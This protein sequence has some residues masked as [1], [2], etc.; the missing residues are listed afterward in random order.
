MPILQYF[1]QIIWMEI[2]F[3][4]IPHTTTTQ[5]NTP[6]TQKLINSSIVV[7]FLQITSNELSF[8]IHFNTYN[9]A[10]SKPRRT[11]INKLNLS[12]HCFI[13]KEHYESRIK[14][15][16]RPKRRKSIHYF[17][18][19]HDISFKTYHQVST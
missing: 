19:V 11:L 1:F 14:T 16:I 6:L 2:E 17:F 8:E 12:V 15:Q 13:I 3:R 5:V 10:S 18:L 4:K 7:M 9:Y